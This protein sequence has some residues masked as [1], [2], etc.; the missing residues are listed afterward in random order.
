MKIVAAAGLGA[1]A[2]V[3]SGIHDLSALGLSYAAIFGALLIALALKRA[4]VQ[5]HSI[6]KIVH[7]GAGVWI[8]PTVRLFDSWVWAIIPALTFI[9][10]NYFFDRLTRTAR[11]ARGMDAGLIF[12]PISYCLLLAICWGNEERNL[13]YI[14]VAGI[15]AMTWGDSM[16]AVI[17]KRWASHSY[18]TRSYIRTWEGTSAMFVFSVVSIA[19][20][21]LWMG[22]LTWSATWPVAIAAG[23]A[24]ATAEAIS[25]SGTDNLTVPLCTAAVIYGLTAMR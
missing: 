19:L 22:R 10:M 13:R 5:Q 8:I 14:A 1:K 9:P 23:F 4:G 18:R 7:I 6:R 12:F 20:T 21:L 25:P 15:M 2:L 16:A 24:A 3:H 17:G 11:S